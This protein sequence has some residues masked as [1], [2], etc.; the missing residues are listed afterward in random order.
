MK[1]SGVTMAGDQH[2]VV[3][4]RDGRVLGISADVDDFACLQEL[5]RKKLKGKMGFDDSSAR[6]LVGVLNGVIKDL[7]ELLIVWPQAE[8][9]EELCVDHTVRLQERAPYHLRDFCFFDIDVIDECPHELY[10][11]GGACLGVAQYEDVLLPHWEVVN[12]LSQLQGKQPRHD[13]PRLVADHIIDQGDRVGRPQPVP[14]LLRYLPPTW[15]Q[16]PWHV[17]DVLCL[18][19]SQ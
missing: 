18:V 12:S 1:V 13:Q 16:L 9:G 17:K 5:W 3:I 2:T 7:T 19:C 4:V 8:G 11:P 14:L 6:H 10:G 15:G